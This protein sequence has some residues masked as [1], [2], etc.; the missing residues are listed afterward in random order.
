MRTA[1]RRKGLHEPGAGKEMEGREGVLLTIG[2][3]LVSP[4]SQSK[5]A[6][7]RAP[8]RPPPWPP[9]MRGR[10]RAGRASRPGTRAAPVRRAGRAAPRRLETRPCGAGGP[11]GSRLPDAP[12]D[13]LP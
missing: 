2:T 5:A 7:L 12:G 11:L 6:A 4:G 9:A 1:Q 13:S 8:H 10:P 3:R